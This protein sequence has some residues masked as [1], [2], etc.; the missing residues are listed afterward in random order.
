MRQALIAL[1]AVTL[2]GAYAAYGDTVVETDSGK[3]IAVPDGWTVEIIPEGFNTGVYDN[4]LNPLGMRDPGEFPLYNYLLY[5]KG[6]WLP[7]D[8]TPKFSPQP[9]C[10]EIPTVVPAQECYA[11]G[12]GQ[13]D[14]VDCLVDPC[15]RRCYVASSPPPTYCDDLYPETP[16]EETCDGVLVISPGFGGDRITCE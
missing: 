15:N 5:L 10:P 16:T 11:S 9:I 8:G 4:N 14:D 1:L 6:C 13:V 12:E 2:M 7:D 3:A